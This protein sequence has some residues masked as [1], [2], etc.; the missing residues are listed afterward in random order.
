MKPPKNRGKKNRRGDGSYGRPRESGDRRDRGGD[1]RKPDGRGDGSHGRSR[2]SAG[3][4]DRGGSFRKPGGFRGSQQ[5]GRDRNKGFGDNSS[6]GF[7]K[8]F[9]KPFHKDNSFDRGGVEFPGVYRLGGKLATKNRY[10]GNRVYGEKTANKGGIEYRFWDPYRSKVAA[11]LAKGLKSF[12]ITADSNVLYLGASSGTTASHI[13]D[14]AA[15]VYCVEFSKRMMRELLQVCEVRKNM[16]PILADARH[17]WQ[18]SNLI[19]SVDVVMQDVAQPDQAGI[20]MN[21]LDT[22]GFKYALLSIKARSI[23]SVGDPK[24]VFKQE[25]ERL[26]QKFNVLQEVSLEPFEEDHI[27]VCLQAK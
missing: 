7:S 14:I 8:G 25:V 21:N 27:L 5:K 15:K 12:P 13:S 1:F 10:S 3:G 19:G 20:L 17:P 26:R 24:K 16:M 23:N 18:Y 22:F 11:A 2:D 6:R 9:N 4:R